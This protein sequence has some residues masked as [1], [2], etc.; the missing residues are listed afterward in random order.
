MI[1]VP[2][3]KQLKLV[4]QGLHNLVYEAT[5]TKDGARVVLR[6]LRPELATPQLI[7]DHQREFKLLSDID[8]EFV[9]KAIELIEAEESPILV[10]E[11]P[12]GRPLIEFVEDKSLD[13]KDAAYIGRLIAKA[14]DDLHSFHVVHKD[15]N[16]ANIVYDPDGASLKLIDFGI[17][18]SLSPSQIKPEVNRTLEGTLPYL[19]PEQTGRMN[20]SVDFRSDFYSLGVTLFHLL[21]GQLPFHGDDNL[22]LIYQH[23]AMS[24]QPPKELNPDIPK[25]LSNIVLKLLSKMPEDRYQSAYAIT[26]DL[27]RF[28]ELT[29]TGQT[30]VDF[31]V[32]LDDISE[33]LNLSERLLER[34]D[35]LIALRKALD[36]VSE[37]ATATI[38]C[39]GEAGS[40]K[41]TLVREVEREVVARGGFLAKGTHNP[42]TVEVP[43]TAVS[44]ALSDLVK[45]L[46]ARPDLPEQKE[47]IGKKLVGL[48]QPLFSLAPELASFLDAEVSEEQVPAVEVKGRLVRGIIAL[49]TAVC[50]GETP[51]IISLDNLHWVDNASIDLFEDLFAAE[52]LPYVMLL[53]CYRT[54]ELDQ[55]ARV[56]FTKLIEHNPDIE[57]LRL[58]NLSV[59]AVNR[60]I[61]ESLFRPEEETLEFAKLVFEKT[62]GN[63]LAVKE[64]LTQIH[65]KGLLT[66]D[67]QHREW[68][69]DI[70]QVTNEPI[71]E[72]V[73]LSL[74]TQL[75]NLEPETTRLLEIAA[76]IG[77]EFDLELLQVVSGLSFSET[78][79][80]L[81]QAIHQGYLLQLAGQSDARDKRVLFRFAHERIQQTAYSLLDNREKRQ[82]HAA[83]GQSLLATRGKSDGRIFDIVNQL[84]N[85]FEWPDS[86]MLDQLHLA[87]LNIEAGHKAKQAAAFQ[88]AF[89]YFR[90]AIALYG[91]NVWVQHDLSLEVHLEAAEAAYLCGDENQL[92]L[93]IS[94]ILDH[95]RSP[96][97]IASAYEI[98]IRAMIAANRLNEAMELA[99]SAL[100]S[101]DMPLPRKPNL[102]TAVRALQVVV[103]AWLMS[104]SD[105]M[106]SKQMAEEKHLAA[107]KL[108]NILCRAAYSAGD[109]RISQYILEMNY[110]SLK[111]GMA[112]ESSFA[113]PM[114]GSMF[115]TYFG[116][117][118]FGYRLGTLALENLND[119]NKELH[120]K[121][122][123]LAYNFN[124]S[125]KDHL[126]LTL[127]PLG[128]A[129]RIGMET[130]DVEFAMIA[131][132]TS[133]AN[134][135]VLGH[136]LHSID[137]N[138]REHIREAKQHKQIPMHNMG[139][140]YLQAVR[141]L[142]D[143]TEAPWLLEGDVFSEDNL[144]NNRESDD[145]GLANLFITKLYLAILF[146]NTERVAEYARSVRRHAN[147][148]EASPA[149]P[150][151]TML[152]SLAFI[153]QKPTLNVFT[154]MQLRFKLRRNLRMLRKWAHH[155]PENILHRYYIVQAEYARYLNQ[156]L[157]AIQFY[158]DTIRHAQNN[159]YLND[160]ALANELAGRFYLESGKRDLAM[161]YISHAA[162]HY[163]R[164]GATNKLRMLMSEFSEI[165]QLAMP[166]Q[167]ANFQ[168][169]SENI[170]SG[171]LIDL[172]TVIR[173]SQV[174]AGEIVLENLLERLMQVSLV[175]AGGNKASLILNRD[176]QLTIEITT[177]IREGEPEYRFE[178]VPLEQ[179]THVPVSIIQY[180]ARTQED[181]VLNN[182]VS[183][184]IFT[185]DDYVLRERP[186]SIL[187]IP[188]ESQSHLTGILYVENSQ[189]TYAFTQD[190]VSVLK[191]LASQSAI[192]IENSKLYQQL[193]DSRNKY[194][195][196]YQ[197]AVEGIF[198]VDE[199]GDITNIN[200]AAASLLG[201][202]STSELR[203]AATPQISSAFVNPDDFK[204]FRERLVK[205]G[206]V[207]DFET[208]VKRKDGQS[209][210]VALSGQVINDA[211]SKQS[212]LE[213]AI[214]D[215][216]ERKLREEAEQ[217][218][219]RAEAATETKSQFL[220]NMSH[221]IRTPMNAIIGYTDLALD[222]ELDHEQV[223]YLHTIRNAS[224]HLLRVVNDILD[225]SRVES[226]K[227]ELEHSAFYLTT[228]FDDLR[229]LFGLAAREKG[230][231]LDI[232]DLNKKHEPAFMGDPIRIG[233]VLIN[234]VGNSIKFTDTGRV[235]VSY[236]EEALEHDQS[237]LTFIVKDSG[238]GIE[239]SQ[240]ETIFESFAQGSATQSD[241]GTGLGL[242][243]SRRLAEMMDG[244]LYA[245]S[246]V[247]KGSTFYFSATVDKLP[248]QIRTVQKK[249]GGAPR[250]LKGTEILLVEDNMINQQL[251]VQMLERNG[252]S[253]AVAE[254]GAEAIEIL[255]RQYYPI[256]LMDIRMPVMDGI[257]AIKII[258]EDTKLKDATVVAL[259]AGVLDNE[260][261]QALEAGFNHYLTKPIDFDALSDLLHRIAASANPLDNISEDFYIRGINFG[262]AI[263]N[264]GGDTEFLINLTGDFINIYG[265]VDEELDSFL[266]KKDIEQ[267]QR[268]IHNIAGLAGTFGADSLMNISREVEYQLRDHGE[269]SEKLLG[270]LSIELNNFVG[271]IDEFR[272]LNRSRTTSGIVGS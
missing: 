26:R 68:T 116:T 244:D 7:A 61:S 180:V 112:P 263:E 45:Q 200:P 120:A 111:H 99:L 183:E 168:Y 117:I 236:T 138:L 170:S 21:T 72:N 142:I 94:S 9:I 262:R 76:C 232:P 182:A 145:T 96:L 140:I 239:E 101:V 134:A 136:D 51:L 235:V 41:S 224:N 185:Q 104:R 198:E 70:Q 121:T 122:I 260:I 73:S 259:S 217:A 193:N 241:A 208:Q 230:L 5:R 90:T 189:S 27:D 131:A 42:I 216:S 75:R 222:T 43:Y 47:N 39:L 107:M 254:N 169:P 203:A 204:T 188:I 139:S 32:A 227:L 181:L 137:T 237:R 93:L 191:L 215:I 17:S 220:A 128:E 67:R 267:A 238:R 213:G 158:E 31:E 82:I 163:K 102:K 79:T 212:K 88:Q 13:V 65:D 250:A 57:L 266:K 20:R 155:S 162:N 129:H 125:W 28:L 35:E 265:R 199:T 249:T 147:A 144:E 34:D 173:A 63:P 176:D 172:E 19:S 210:W 255:K 44:T 270:E 211:K 261:D 60:L 14:I 221:E 166:T 85:S 148:V 271:A 2:G 118:D 179:A 154:Q 18:S 95:A 269:V 89:K 243:I 22:E 113:Y 165:S 152:E 187:C 156:D 160:L 229:N 264:H 164:W 207:M 24:P 126:N 150:F 194:L 81:S 78:S 3:Y 98:Q 161:Y 105:Q 242:S 25:A 114:L 206:R 80:R 4:H 202:D 15:I 119:D 54:A 55:S 109:S 12:P 71:S 186:R 6:Q 33:Q 151:F 29:V 50:N 141:N 159:G 40:G 228:V 127:E 178:S 103:H 91:Q 123:S 115:I 133:S 214:V 218:R 11:K 190:R 234:L 132:I 23:M 257:E 108:L 64:F 106:Q 223:D 1:S 205:N 66:F 48:E 87:E 49:L 56:T 8:S 167:R 231:E 36:E 110:L 135:F 38:A 240:L 272:A 97:E 146:G 62:N 92:D 196:L 177:W 59:E 171:N 225:L 86:G 130:Q 251:A 247:G 58:D 246:K 52:K 46:L 256:I 16:P 268:L 252:L 124:R 245:N 197:N 233:Q 175:N 53:G 84:N 184:D 219:L 10:T 83:I 192:A 143:E 195:S 74:I 69:W 248:E 157:K 174:L 201:Y 149:V 226:G 253:V 209:V 30:D 77:T 258:R 153:Y 37:G 100:D